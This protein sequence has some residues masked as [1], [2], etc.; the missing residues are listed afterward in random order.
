MGMRA[1]ITGGTRGIGYGIAECLVHCG[2]DLII[3]GRRPEG[4]INEELDALRKQGHFIEYC[5]G[6]ISL[7]NDRKRIV[8][9]AAKQGMI[10]LLVNNAGV[11][12]Q[13]RKDILEMDEESFDFVMDVN[14]KGTFFLTQKIARLMLEEKKRTPAYGGMIITI[15]SISAE[16]VSL[17]RGEYCISKAG[18][19]MM[20]RL[21]AAR[22]GDASIPVYEVRPGIVDTDMTAGA[23]E[24]YDKL[25]QEGLTIDKRWGTPEDV[26]KVVAALATGMLP[27]ST[28]N[29]ITVDGGMSI[30]RL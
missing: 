27:Y 21:M 15:T 1:L 9:Q 29:V 4:D 28:G 30:R 20:S 14:L 10:N 12:P 13:I 11:A 8:D 25:I 2:F 24:K 17:N 7:E 26:G 22:L 16:V 23:R 6:D 5:Q 19:T 3:N 18:L